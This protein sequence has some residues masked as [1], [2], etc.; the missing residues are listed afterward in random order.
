MSILDAAKRFVSKLLFW[1]EKVPTPELNPFLQE[2]FEAKEKLDSKPVPTE[3]TPQ[4]TVEE[5]EKTP[6]AKPFETQP[7]VPP[8]EPEP[9]IAFAISEI[10]ELRS[11]SK[12]ESLTQHVEEVEKVADITA[13]VSIWTRMMQ[14]D[15]GTKMVVWSPDSVQSMAT[16]DEKSGLINERIL[17]EV[18]HSAKD[19]YAFLQPGLKELAN[20]EVKSIR[21]DDGSKP[22]ATTFTEDPTFSDSFVLNPDTNSSEDT[23]SEVSNDQ[24]REMV[25]QCSPDFRIT[26]SRT[27]AISDL[28]EATLESPMDRLVARILRKRLESS[29]G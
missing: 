6:A 17:I 13:A 11:F 12:K 29:K 28:D 25:S 23:V 15:A 9:A 22:V 18:A 4:T 8:S 2:L 27:V 24:L 19:P 21:I 20:S 16:I 5:K 7:A 14:K 3:Q 1:R 26:L 10:G